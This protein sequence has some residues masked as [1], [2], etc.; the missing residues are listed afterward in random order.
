MTLYPFFYQGRILAAGIP[1][2]L[3]DILPGEHDASILDS[4][5]G[6]SR[7]QAVRY[8]C[9]RN[10]PVS[11]DAKKREGS[12]YRTIPAFMRIHSSLSGIAIY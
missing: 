1:E 3:D 6:G 12:A 2:M 4:S 11:Q 9:Y 10:H 5:P 7:R 8:I